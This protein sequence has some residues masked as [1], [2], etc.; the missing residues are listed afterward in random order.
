MLWSK[1]PTP[2]HDKARH[3]GIDLTSSRARAVSLGGGKSRT[4]LLDDAA[5]E[6]PLFVALDRRAPEV[7]R[8]GYAICRKTPHAACSN[9]L[10]ALGQTRE[11]RVGRHA[12]TP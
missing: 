12:L 4:L 7:G 2:T 8:T 10:P 11:W 9:F 1:R 5:E 3:V 6:L